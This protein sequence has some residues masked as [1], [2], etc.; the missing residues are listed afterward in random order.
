MT[1]G[2]RLKGLAMLVTLGTKV[3]VEQ[4]DA[5]YALA[6]SLE[7]T[8]SALV[9]DLIHRFLDGDIAAF[10]GTSDLTLATSDDV[11]RSLVL[12]RFIAEHIDADETRRLMEETDAFLSEQQPANGNDLSAFQS[13]QNGQAV[14]HG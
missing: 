4:R 13:D 11:T 12:V 2:P 9:R 5:F 8:P 14:R 3:T 7:T 1:V 6:D 10:E